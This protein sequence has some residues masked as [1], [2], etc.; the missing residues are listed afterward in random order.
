M[1]IPYELNQTNMGDNFFWASNNG[2]TGRVDL[3]VYSVPYTEKDAFTL[4]K[5]IAR[6]D[7]IMKKNIPGA[8][9]DSYMTTSTFVDPVYRALSLDG[10]YVGETRGLWEVK[11]DVMGGPFVSHTRLDEANQRIITA[12]VF[13]YAPES[14]KRN[15]VRKA[16]AALYTLKLPQDNLLP[17]VPVLITQ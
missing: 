10:K 7:S 16:E 1:N 17:E 14:K 9:K 12:E 6:R 11:G 13:V 5:I 3:F 2:R 15:L 4:S 8:Y